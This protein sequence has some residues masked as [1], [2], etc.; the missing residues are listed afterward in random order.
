MVMQVLLALMVRPFASLVSC[1]TRYTTK[2][3]HRMVVMMMVMIML[4]RWRL[5]VMAVGRGIGQP[6]GCVPRR[7]VMMMP[8]RIVV[9]IVAV[10]IV[11]VLL[12]VG[13]MMNVQVV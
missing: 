3:I 8:L 11:V 6:G 4:V 7:C 12:V 9:V 13:M 10:V 2:T 1:Y 5:L